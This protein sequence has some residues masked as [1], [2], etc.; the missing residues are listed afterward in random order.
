MFHLSPFFPGI[1]KKSYSPL[2]VLFLEQGLRLTLTL[3]LCVP[4]ELVVGLHSSVPSSM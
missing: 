1:I 2:P 3:S 4:G